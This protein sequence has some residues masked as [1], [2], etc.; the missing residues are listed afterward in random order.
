VTEAEEGRVL[1]VEDSA[2]TVGISKRNETAT[3]TTRRGLLRILDERNVAII[4]RFAVK[5]TVSISELSGTK[6]N[7][8]QFVYK[9]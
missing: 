5:Y 1:P 6:W 4:S 2:K 8:L 3:A 7:V 9:I